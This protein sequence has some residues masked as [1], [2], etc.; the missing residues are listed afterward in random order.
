VIALE[1]QCRALGVVK[2][3][4]QGCQGG[5]ADNYEIRPACLF[6]Q[7]FYRPLAQL[8]GFRFIGGGQQYL[9][10]G[11]RGDDPFGYRGEFLQ[12]VGLASAL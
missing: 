4:Q 12:L 2:R 10:R 7:P 8:P 1:D 11:A 5:V 3:P 9:A 6:P